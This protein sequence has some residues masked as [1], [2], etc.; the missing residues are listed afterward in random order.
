[1]ETTMLNYLIELSPGF[2]GIAVQNLFSGEIDSETSYKKDSISFFMYTTISWITGNFLNS[3]DYIHNIVYSNERFMI[4]LMIISGFAGFCWTTFLKKWIEKVI[5]YINKS[6]NKNEIFLQKTLIEELTKDN[7]PHYW[8]VYKD[9][10]IIAEGWFENFVPK[11][12]SFSLK[13]HCDIDNITYEKDIRT[14]ENELRTIFILDK[15]FYIK[16]YMPNT[17]ENQKSESHA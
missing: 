15:N 13:T 5:N 4:L 6:L 2:I 12:K 11:E 10:S 7:K 1:M 8:V 17:V 9:N 16:E 14:D 3:S